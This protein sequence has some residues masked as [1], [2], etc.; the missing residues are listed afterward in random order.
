ME[1]KGKNFLVT[2]ACGGIGS[3]IVEELILLGANK[4]YAADLCIDNVTKV[5]K[6][7]GDVI[8][9][10][11][12]DITNLESIKS[13]AM[14]CTDIEGLFNNAGVKH[15][16]SI[17]FSPAAAVHE[18]EINYIGVLNLTSA[19]IDNILIKKE[20]CIVNILSTASLELLDDMTGYC[21][22]KSAAHFLT[23]GMRKELQNNN[24]KVYSVYP[25]FLDAGMGNVSNTVKGSAKEMVVSMLHYIEKGIEEILPRMLYKQK[26]LEN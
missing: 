13:C 6:D 24:V 25:G 21:A 14:K 11:G 20:A 10:V 19:L 18:M 1:I 3:L 12:L 9:P 22:S 2:G 8:V 17:L 4:I 15:S 26:N 23:L 16:K 5:F 7:K